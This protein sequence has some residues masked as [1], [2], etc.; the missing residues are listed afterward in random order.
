[1]IIN[2]N[3]PVVRIDSNSRRWN[4]WLCLQMNSDSLNNVHWTEQIIPPPVQR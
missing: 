1:M 3:I 2:D 4:Y